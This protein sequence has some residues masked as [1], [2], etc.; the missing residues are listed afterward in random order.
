[1]QTLWVSGVFIEMYKF[2]SFWYQ[3]LHFQL[4]YSITHHFFLF[5]YTTMLIQDIHNSISLS[6]PAQNLPVS[7]IFSP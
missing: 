2:T 1:M 7:Q 5:W 4:T 3:F 6:L